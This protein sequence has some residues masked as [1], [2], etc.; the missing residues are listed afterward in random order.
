MATLRYFEIWIEEVKV[1]FGKS[2]IEIQVLFVQ[3]FKKNV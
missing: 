1:E 2:G 3:N